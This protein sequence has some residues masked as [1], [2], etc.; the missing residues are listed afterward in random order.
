MRIVC[1][2]RT[3]TTS[4]RETVVRRSI[5]INPA[6]AYST[7][8]IER[9][10]VGRRGGPRRLALVTGLRWPKTG[11]KLTVEFLDTKSNGLKS[12]ILKHM[13]AWSEMANVEFVETTG[14]GM[15]RIARLKT[16]V[17]MAGYWSYVGTEI[18]GIEED[19]PTMNL[20]GFTA[21][22]PDAEF[23]RVVRH[24]AGHTLGFDHEH[25]RKELIKKI[26]R[27]KAI[28]YFDLVEGWTKE[29]TVE[30]VLTPLSKR[31]IMGTTEA[32]PI[33]IMCYEIPG[34]I[35][36]D[37]MPIVGGDDIS[38]K[39]AEF[40]A[41]V[42]PKKQVE[43]S[44]KSETLASTPK[45]N[46]VRERED[47]SAFK[48]TILSEFEPEKK[49]GTRAKKEKP[50]F[51]QVLA[52][53]AG[54]RVSSSMRLK[55][56]RKGDGTAFGRIIATHERIKNYTNELKGTLPQDSELTNFGIDLFETLFQGD[57]R[58]LYDEARSRRGNNKL[59]IVLTS[60]IPWIAEKPWE[61]AFDPV[62]QSFLATEEI[63][64]VRNVLT[65][66]PASEVSP[67]PG[68]LKILVVSAQPISF[69]K[70][71]V[72]EET[73]VIERGFKPLIKA[74]LVSID[75][76]ARV[77]PSQL[78]QH[79]ST[80][81][82]SVVHFIGHGTFDEQSQEGAL[83]FE[84]GLG[85]EI[86]L[87]ERSVREIFCQRGIRL[88]FLNSCQ[89]GSGGKSEF[90]KGVAQSLVA[91]GIPALVANQYSV[92]DSSATSFSK[93]FYWALAKGMTIGRAACEARIAVNYGITGEPID[94]AVPVV[95]ARDPDMTL[96][97]EQP[98]ISLPNPTFSETVRRQSLER[99]QTMKI[100]VWDID[101]LFPYLENTLEKMNDAQTE[102]SFELAA[103]SPPMGVWDAEAEDGQPY[104]HAPKLAE[105]MGHATVE[106]QVN[107]LACIS[108]RWMRDEEW[109][110]IYGWWPNNMKPPVVVFSAAGFDLDPSGPETDRAIMNVMISGLAGV[111][112][113]IGTHKS[114]SPNCP[115]F[116]DEGR[117]RESLIGVQKFDRSCRTKLTR[118]IPAKLAAFE[119]IQKAFS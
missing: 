77:T 54:A 12:K 36:K 68:P 37:G 107:I 14:T 105:K 61:F 48:I 59:D 78:H 19:Q 3:L 116:F 112:G 74:G 88:V 46:C 57:V 56:K 113:D 29:E 111:L 104:L 13:N 60:M 86:T 49:Q 32:D 21:R 10:D 50:M 41:M 103:L 92:L 8:T 98:E 89:S 82:F 23:R 114:G 27:Q 63:H 118:K 51:A 66:I 76:V 22:T 18:L 71:S 34:E 64:L 95:Y 6:N 26:D 108:G 52:S 17:D 43:P 101:N 115:L 33:S 99:K 31:S 40:A 5:E 65:A 35:T 87:G 70:L 106:L 91:H 25:M 109:F 55:A 85:G 72:A 102:L 15:V 47:D 100:S 93:H 119:L 38:A 53:F 83:I 110:N 1:R 7:K 75:I 39:D 79:L 9:T 69:D 2:P 42:Y 97:I 16:P 28:K 67:T 94:W 11:I 20:E 80:G 81:K 4:Q 44:R 62:R 73:R 24:E 30:Q 58:R 84:D 96:A 45:A 90:N 117:D